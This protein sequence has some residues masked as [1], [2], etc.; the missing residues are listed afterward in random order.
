[1]VRSL[2]LKNHLLHRA[3]IKARALIFLFCSHGRLFKR[4][5]NQD[6][7]VK[8]VNTVL[9]SWNILLYYQN[10]VRTTTRLFSMLLSSVEFLIASEIVYVIQ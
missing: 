7:A 4:A 5:L 3:G 8:R 1:M 10:D 9:K 6:R 2:P